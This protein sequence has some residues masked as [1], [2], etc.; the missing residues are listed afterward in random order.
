[1]TCHL[2]RPLLNP[3][4]DAVTCVEQRCNYEAAPAEYCKSFG[5]KDLCEILPWVKTLHME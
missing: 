3:R 2:N 4:I 1:M 5:E